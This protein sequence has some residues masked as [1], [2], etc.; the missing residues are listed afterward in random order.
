MVLFNLYTFP[1]EFPSKKKHG[2][3]MLLRFV[4]S[5]KIL[6]V[7]NYHHQLFMHLRERFKSN[8]R[9]VIQLLAELHKT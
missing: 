7:K 5:H 6:Y 8:F 9:R 2:Q 1:K 4:R 3:T